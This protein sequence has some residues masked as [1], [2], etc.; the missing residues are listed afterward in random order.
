DDLAA[1]GAD[2]LD[3]VDRDVARARDH[4]A[5]PGE[6]GALGRQHALD[7]V[8]GS[9]AGRLLARARSTPAQAL[10][11]QHAGLVAVG[12]ALVLAEHVADLALADADVARGHVGVLASMAVELGHERLAEAHDL[13]V[14]PAT[15]IEV[16][17]ALAAADRHAGQR[18]L[19]GLLESQEL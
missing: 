7:E 4:G 6:I 10:A 2:L 9:V 11:G 3:R 8:N 16:G 13:P 18:V 5:L 12:D 1:E 15:R 19:E 17:A 14:G